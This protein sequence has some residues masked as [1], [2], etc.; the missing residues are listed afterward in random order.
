MATYIKFERALVGEVVEDKVNVWEHLAF[1]NYVQKAMAIPRES[2]TYDDFKCSETTF[3]NVVN[4]FNPNVI[5]CWGQRLY[6]KI[7][8]L[9]DMDKELSVQLDENDEAIARHYSDSNMFII[10]I[11]HPASAFSWEYWH[12]SLVAIIDKYMK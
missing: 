1:Y 5:I 8:H 10:P 2:P 6:S 7:P 9:N 4:R 12:E 3:W 11:Y